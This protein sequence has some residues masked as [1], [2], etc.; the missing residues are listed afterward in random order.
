MNPSPPIAS[1]AGSQPRPAEAAATR[2]AKYARL[3]VTGL[4]S[5]AVSATPTQGPCFTQ[6]R[7]ATRA[8]D[9]DRAALPASSALVMRRGR[10]AIL[11]MMSVTEATTTRNPGPHGS[12][13]GEL[14]VVDN[15]EISGWAVD[16][17]SAQAPLI[18]IVI[19][20]TDVTRV[21]ADRRT[22]RRTVDG[23]AR[24]CGFRLT[25]H[26]TL[27]E[28]LP[29][30]NSVEA[31]FSDGQLL[32]T[33]PELRSGL[34]GTVGVEPDELKKLLD[35][36]YSLVAKSGMLIR[37]ISARPGWEDVALLA[38]R[39]VQDTFQSITGRNLFVSYGTLLGLVR[40]G[41][42]IGHDDD[43]DAMFLLDATDAETAGRELV[44]V[45]AELE[46]NGQEVPDIYPW[47]NFH[48]MSSAG[49][50]FD[51]FGCWVQDGTIN[52]YMF[53]FE[54]ARPDVLPVTEQQLG[55]V[56]VSTPAVPEKFLA[57]IYGEDWRIPNPHFQWQPPDEVLIRMSEFATGVRSSTH[58]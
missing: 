49:I 56:K 51:I 57:G 29:S 50:M 27:R 43:I 10:P 24:A 40:N 26:T 28:R 19:N 55:P 13:V 15:N 2:R 30:V 16:T 25:V 38:Y 42:L 12:K 48:W 46:D 54:G 5:A 22:H 52:G 1:A 37:T 21:P 23:L 32:S 9:Y 6:R 20:G 3:R 58:S 44:Q 7:D 36:G 8:V 4:P 17:S 45:A 31:R 14:L 11:R 53:S 41:R 35:E 39:D 18:T 33:P 47:G 34:E